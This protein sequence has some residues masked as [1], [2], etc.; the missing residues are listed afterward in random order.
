MFP[1]FLNIEAKFQDT[2]AQKVQSVDIKKRAEVMIGQRINIASHQ[3]SVVIRA[4]YTVRWL[5]SMYR[6]LHSHA[7]AT[8]KRRPNKLSNLQLWSKSSQPSQSSQTA[9]TSTTST[10]KQP[11]A[12][13]RSRW[14][15]LSLFDGLF[16]L[17]VDKLDNNS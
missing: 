1:G 3:H 6:W 11:T 12:S 2:F 16:E 8:S 5:H 14:D 13:T 10:W 4:S 7:D 15:E 9:R 17:F